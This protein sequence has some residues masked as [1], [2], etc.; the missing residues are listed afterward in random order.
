[1][2]GTLYAVGTP[3]GN[4]EDMSFR[5]VDTLK[6][7][8]II[9]AEDTRHTIKL[10][11]HFDIHTKMVAYH[12]YNEKGETQKLMAHLVK[13]SNVALVSDAGMPVISDPGYI[14]IAACREAGIPVSV[15]PG[16]NAALAAVV[17]SGMDCRHFTFYGFLGKQNKAIREGLE[18]AK[19]SF[20]PTVFYETPHRIQKILERIDGA[21]P[22]RIIS[23]S[24]EMTKQYE[25]TRKGTAAD[26]LAWFND[27]PPKG[28]FVMIVDGGKALVSDAITALCQGKIEDHVGY[29]S[30]QGLSEKEAMKAVAKD[31]KISKRAVYEQV[32]IKEKT[33]PF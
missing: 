22:E 15:I 6:K 25:E 13:G 3:I 20:Y 12:Q 5:A 29:Y 21:M 26:H 7:V 2:N 30:S 17:L 19:A 11:N 14:L 1:M 4:L 27:H 32:K 16:P 18:Q 28:E 23:I 33:E 9:A 24:R 8:D 31:R 10:L